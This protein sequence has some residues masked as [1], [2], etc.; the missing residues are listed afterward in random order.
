MADKVADRVTLRNIAAIAGV[1][2][3]TV[4]RALAG[5]EGVSEQTRER[6][7]HLAQQLGI[8][9]QPQQLG[10]GEAGAATGV[11]EPAASQPEFAP[12]L[13]RPGL[14]VTLIIDSR[15]NPFLRDL[16][17][18]PFYLELIAGLSEASQALGYRFSIEM[19]TSDE[20]LVAIFRHMA[21]EVDWR[22]TTAGEIVL[23][24]RR[25]ALS[26]IFGRGIVWLGYQPRD[27]YVPWV[28][29]LTR[30]GVPTVLCD[31]YVS[32]LPCDAVVSDNI[33]GARELGAHVASLGHRRV[34]ILR[35]A[36]SSA[37]SWERTLGFQTACYEAG[38]THS[39]VKLIV[40]DPTFE[41][42]YEALP[43]A[44]ADGATAILCGN[45]MMAMGVLRRAAE[46]GVRVPEALSVCG[47]DDIATSR[48]LTPALTTAGVDQRAI[49]REALRRLWV[50]SQLALAAIAEASEKAQ[51]ESREVAGN[52]MAVTGEDHGCGE[53]VEG[54][55]IVVPT[56]LIVRE[57][58]G[59]APG[60]LVA[61]GVSRPASDQ[62]E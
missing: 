32:G 30:L 17:D 60:K 55:R 44:L 50:R 62:E 56:R 29:V 25:R 59:P 6:I 5:K 19:V 57:T 3:S 15:G 47:F 43:E 11:D 34:C 12:G 2:P 37:A 1:A 52:G 8:K 35:Q 33:G 14:A 13:A 31:H 21:P 20:D 24:D 51:D 38:L 7:V 61:V 45:D 16:S 36:L 39:D 18:N 27:A 4:Y 49:G 22:R 53:V 26:R 10:A 54:V 9:I 28:P 23:T 41:G 58:T 40:A 48:R 46:L 42:G